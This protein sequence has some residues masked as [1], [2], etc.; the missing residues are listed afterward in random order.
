MLRQIRLVVEP[1]KVCAWLET[2]LHG[3]ICRLKIDGPGCFRFRF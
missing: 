3:G 1:E 2:S